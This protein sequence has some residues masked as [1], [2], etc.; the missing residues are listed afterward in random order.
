MTGG[1]DGGPGPRHTGGDRSGPEHAHRDSA[2][3][4]WSDRVLS[5]SDAG[6]DVGAADPELAAALAEGGDEAAVMAAV[7]GA[8]FLVPVLA[9][10]AESGEVG[11]RPAD[12]RADMAS[13]TLVAADGQRALP[14]FTSL[15]SLARWDPAA[16]PVPVSAARAGR[17]AVTESCDVIVIDVAGPASAVLR[18]SMVWALAQERDWLPPHLDPFVSGSVTRAV[19]VEEDVVEHDVEEGRP[20]GRGVLGVVLTLRPGLDPE[21][22]RAV[23]TRVGERLAADGEFRARVDG[24]AFRIV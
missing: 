19:L 22:V 2:G 9:R 24:L 6:A 5:S 20:A 15:E 4:P 17:A 10:L 8:R 23:A 11:G 16:R 21:A 13:V 12:N 3:V 14:V 1:A 7:R 18:S